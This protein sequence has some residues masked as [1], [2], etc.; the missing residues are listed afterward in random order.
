MA[1]IT[2]YEL[3]HYNNG[4][5]LPFT[6]NLD[7]LSEFEYREA[8]SEVLAEL[9]EEYEED[10]EAMRRTPFATF[11][12]WI[13]CDTD[14]V[15]KSLVGEY[16]LDP[17]WF[18]LE[19]AKAESPYLED[20][21]WEAGVELGID[22]EHIAEAYQ[23]EYRSDEAFAEQLLDDTGDLG[24]IPERLQYYFDYEKFARDLMIGDYMQEDGH[25]FSRNW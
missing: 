25:Y 9:K 20:E 11:E 16:D 4:I 22:P 15:P 17:D 21:V 23:G 1:T 7:G 5:L 2:L 19:E 14:G 18:K 8:I 12:E 13:V 3:S 10:A 24:Q 6:I